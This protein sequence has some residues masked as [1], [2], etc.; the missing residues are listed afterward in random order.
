MK[1]VVAILMGLCSASIVVD[2]VRMLFGNVDG[3]MSVPIAVNIVVFFLCAPAGTWLVLRNAASWQRL[4]FNG[5]S[6]GVIEW[7][8][9]IASCWI[10]KYRV[11]SSLVSSGAS[12]RELQS[13]AISAGVTTGLDVM[14]ALFSLGLC[15]VGLL[16]TKNSRNAPT[17][18]P[19]VSKAT[20]PGPS[21]VGTSLIVTTEVTLGA[22]LI[23]LSKESDL[24][25]VE[26]LGAAFMIVA[27][28]SMLTIIAIAGLVQGLRLL[29][30]RRYRVLGFIAVT[31]SAG[32]ILFTGIQVTQSSLELQRLDARNAERR[33]QYR[34][35]EPVFRSP[36]PLKS[37]YATTDEL[38]LVFA[39]ELEAHMPVSDSEALSRFCNDFLVGKK[40]DVRMPKE[41]AFLSRPTVNVLYGR[42]NLYLYW[43]DLVR[44]DQYGQGDVNRV[45]KLAARRVA[46]PSAPDSIEIA[47]IA[48]DLRSFAD[49]NGSGFLDDDEGRAFRKLIEFG[50]EAAELSDRG[51]SRGRIAKET[52]VAQED[53]DERAREYDRMADRIQYAGVVTPVLSLPRESDN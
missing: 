18:R 7:L 46:L 30:A 13:Q 11:V 9:T 40:L 51:I 6:L 16:L 43:E 2:I 49:A 10:Y 28:T 34:K 20:N 44:V 53:L 29:K 19:A 4:V 24:G 21:V 52:G 14:T 15:I 48:K 32:P 5:C 3:G 42:K 27:G 31:V 33:A 26:S 37:S 8:V 50:F 23:A 35:M 47:R 41:D 36:Q 39:D 45:A 17:T 22:L 1:L 38:V 25:L 12:K